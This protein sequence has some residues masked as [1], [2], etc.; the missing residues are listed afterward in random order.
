MNIAE[1]RALSLTELEQLLK[2][3]SASFEKGYPQAGAMATKVERVIKEKRDLGHL[4]QAQA[5]EKTTD[6]GEVFVA[7]PQNIAVYLD[8]NDAALAYGKAHPKETI[9]DFYTGR[10]AD[11]ED[12]SDE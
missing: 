8:G 1:M 4:T 9:L 12:T 3:L 6:E 2:G 5:H 10:Y 7:Y 11:L